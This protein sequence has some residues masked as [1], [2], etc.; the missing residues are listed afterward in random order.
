MSGEHH[1]K[2]QKRKLPHKKASKKPKEIDAPDLLNDKQESLLD[3]IF[4][5]FQAQN[6]HIEKLRFRIKDLSANLKSTNKKIL[7]LT[8]R[9]ENI[10]RMYKI[11]NI[12]KVNKNEHR[13]K[14][15]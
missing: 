3:A 15:T 5:L 7:K 9:I 14:T 12:E 1:K 6:D 10:E 4:Y 8:K 13:T 11:E 2:L